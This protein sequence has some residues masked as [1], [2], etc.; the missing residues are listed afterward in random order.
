MILS[1]LFPI[2]FLMLSPRSSR[3][4]CWWSSCAAYSILVDGEQ[5]SKVV[6]RQHVMD[7]APAIAWGEETEPASLHD[8]ARISPHIV[9]LMRRMPAPSGRPESYLFSDPTATEDLGMAH[10][11]CIY[12]V[13]L[14]H[15]T[16]W[17]ISV[18]ISVKPKLKRATAICVTLSG[19]PYF[20]FCKWLQSL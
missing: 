10:G 6:S 17:R 14:L 19:W 4:A 18:V 7:L 9:D 2:R 11:C 12:Y 3:V 15:T 5:P 16:L 1:R 13:N 20:F 8:V